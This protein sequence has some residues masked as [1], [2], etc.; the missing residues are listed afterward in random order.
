M[1]IS[2]SESRHRCRVT[3][4]GVE[5]GGGDRRL[6]SPDLVDRGRLSD[7]RCNVTQ[8]LRETRV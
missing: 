7:R 3:D 2:R 5:V 6:E 8:Y 4:P 1:A